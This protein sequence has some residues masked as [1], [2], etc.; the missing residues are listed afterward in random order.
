MHVLLEGIVPYVMALFLNHCIFVQKYFTLEWLNDKIKSY[1]YSK[2]DKSHKPETI[3]KNSIIKNVKLKQTSTGMLTIC[4]VFPHI[5][6]KCIPDDDAKFFNLIR[7]FQ[8][9]FLSTT[10]YV[11][12]STSGELEQ[13]IATHHNEFVLLYPTE[14]IKPKFHYLVH[15]P[16]QLKD[17]GP[18]RGQWCLRFEGKHMFFK[19]FKWRNTV[20]LEKSLAEKHQLWMAYKMI[21]GDGARSSTFLY[22]GDI[23]VEGSMVSFSD[24]VSAQLEDEFRNVCDHEHILVPEPLVV[25]RCIEVQIHGQLY[26]AGCHCALFIDCNT[27]N[28]PQ[29]A[30]FR[31]IIVLNDDKF[32]SVEILKTKQFCWKL[33]SY[34]VECQE[35]LKIIYF[36]TL[37]NNWPLPVFRDCNNMY[38]SNRN[39]HFVEYLC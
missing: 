34:E 25:Y 33:N 38:I 19:N 28:I 29:F 6:G 31:E 14:K 8:I 7:L 21:S 30:L 26:E 24:L 22:E 18:L 39:G 35:D 36:Q 17:F 11:D 27:D 16:Q 12:D 20:N 13:L 2:R 15:F 32:F 5:A 37:K 1:P 9:V 4:Y 23:V 10:P 3:E